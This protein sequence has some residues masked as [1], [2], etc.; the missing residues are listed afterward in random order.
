MF[1]E[2]IIVNRIIQ[3]LLSLNTYEMYDRLG[4]SVLYAHRVYHGPTNEMDVL[5]FLLL[6]YN[7]MFIESRGRVLPTQNSNPSQRYRASQTNPSSNPKLTGG[8]G[9]GDGPRRSGEGVR[10]ALLP[11]V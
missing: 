8:G 10:G 6:M 4:C 7:Q 11:H 5:V 3:L 9:G 1:C 2:Q